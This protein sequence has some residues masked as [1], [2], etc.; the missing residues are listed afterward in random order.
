VII[1]Q[2]DL[3]PSVMPK[4][5][6]TWRFALGA[7]P[8]VEGLILRL[9]TEDGAVGYGYASA[10][11]HMGSVMGTLQAELER[12]RPLVV[13]RDPASIEA[14]LASLEASL[15]GAPQAKAAVDCALYDLLGSAHGIP[16]TQ[17]FGGPDRDRVPILRILAIKSPDEMAAN[18]QK[19]VDKGYRYLKI[20]VHGEVELDVARVKAIRERAGTQAHLT[21]DANQSYTPKDAIF[22]INRMAPHGIDL[23]EQPVSR[24]DLKGLEL[25]TRSVP[26]TVEADEGAGTRQDIMTLVGNRIVDAVS[27]KI[28]KLGGIRNALAAARICEAG[29]VRCRLGAHVGSRL[30]NA[31]AI[32]LAVALP[33]VDYACEL[34]EF[35]RMYDDPFAGIEVVDGMLAVPDRP[36]SGV[37][38]VAARKGVA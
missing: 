23:V 9:A 28:P 18:A 7:N 3:A 24:H 6:P 35:S 11:P 17:L 26:V 22:A 12:F 1:R 4:D 38:P 21:I 13:G 20:K 36:G 14:I 31:F 37:E 33:Q 30:L 32:H 16:L 25:V 34:G 27:L 15:R 2:F 8:T 29:G 19:L 10:V 5:D